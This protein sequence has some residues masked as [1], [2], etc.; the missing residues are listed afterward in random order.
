M[1]I[2]HAPFPPPPVPRATENPCARWEV[3]SA[4]CDK[5]NGKEVQAA[6]QV[7]GADAQV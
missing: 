3:E 6:C 4:D 1:P 2:R 5:R 7:A